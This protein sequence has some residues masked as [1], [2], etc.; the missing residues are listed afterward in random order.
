M[1]LTAKRPSK[2]EETRDKLMRDVQDRGGRK[3]RL[4]VDMADTLYREIKARA[5]MEDR[6]ISEITIQLWSEYLGK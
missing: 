5:A 1:A 3:R 6:S 2:R 4:N